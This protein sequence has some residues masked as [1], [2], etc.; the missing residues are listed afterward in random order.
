MSPVMTLRSA[1]FIKLFGRLRDAVFPFGR[2][3]AVEP[4]Y[5]NIIYDYISQESF[6]TRYHQPASISMRHR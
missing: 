1:T 5:N 3:R 4:I 2:V 6:A